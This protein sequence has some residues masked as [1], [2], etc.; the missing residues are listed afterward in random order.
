MIFRLTYEITHDQA[1]PGQA[2]RVIRL[3]LECEPASADEVTEALNGFLTAVTG[4][5]EAL[6]Q[7]TRSNA[8]EQ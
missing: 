1:A 8:G 4:E 2:G 3:D 7:D 5:R 6:R